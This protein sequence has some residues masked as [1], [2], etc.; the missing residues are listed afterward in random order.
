MK[1]IQILTL[2][3]TLMAFSFAE[4]TLSL[5]AN[6]D[7]IWNVNFSSDADIGGFQFDVD[8]V[9]VN[10]ASGGEAS[11][12]SDNVNLPTGKWLYFWSGLLNN[13]TKAE[14]KPII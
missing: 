5:E 3:L 11:Y 10:S 4:N 1:T 12:E 14:G 7:G 9:I 2:L 13:Y 6:G 8:D